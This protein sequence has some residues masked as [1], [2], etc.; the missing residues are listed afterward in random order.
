MNLLFLFIILLSVLVCSII[1]SRFLPLYKGQSPIQEGLISFSYSSNTFDKVVI[2]QYSSS[3]NTVVKL[4][5]N[6]FFDTVNAN[7]IIVNGVVA[8]PGCSDT[9]SG[10]T[11]AVSACTTTTIDN[12]IIVLTRDSGG[13]TSSST[14][15]STTISTES[16]ISTITNTISSWVYKTK[17]NNDNFTALYCAILQDTYVHLIDSNNVLTVSLYLSSNGKKLSK[18]YD[19][20]NNVTSGTKVDKDTNNGQ[21]VYEQLYNMTSYV[22]KL[23]HSVLYDN[24]SKLLIVKQSSD[25]AITVYNS[26]GNIITPT[27]GYINTIN[28]PQDFKSVCIS[29]QEGFVIF[30]QYLNQ[31]CMVVVTYNNN[32]F[33]ILRTAAFNGSMLIMNPNGETT[34]PTSDLNKWIAYW[35]VFNKNNNND[36]HILKTQIVPMI[37]ADDY[38]NNLFENTERGISNI[39]GEV[40]D[41]AEDAV[42]GTVGIARDAVKGTVDLTKDTVGGAV[43][44]TKDAVKG[45][46][47]LTKDTVGGAVDLAEDVAG[48]A[49]G[50]A[51]SVVGGAVELAE[52]ATKSSP[53]YIN[54]SLG[55]S[56]LYQSNTSI[57]PG[58]NPNYSPYMQGASAPKTNG[59]DIYSYFGALPDKGSN[60]I[61]ITSNFS[62]FGK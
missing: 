45:T 3:V 54:N 36:D 42:E 61:P 59:N 2:P 14:K 21:Y 60:F 46:V 12:G 51:G 28:T 20:T 47:D 24:N 32:T 29:C 6:F 18:M 30:S 55:T 35:T 56:P 8:A 5:D 43:G 10:C 15:T 11:K 38:R 33:S 48:G 19:S 57:Q 22:Y 58:S 39:V 41:L 26:N 40:V 7:L 62:S 13:I 16:K 37:S 52:N 9:V 53:L 1:F 27:N 4:Y 31:T 34:N 23:T 50:L 49:L 17:F 25:Q 44:L